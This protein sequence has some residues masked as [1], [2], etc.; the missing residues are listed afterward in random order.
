MVLSYGQGNLPPSRGLTRDEAMRNYALGLNERHS[1]ENETCSR[2]GW[3][4]AIEVLS[5]L[6]DL[7][8]RKKAVT[9]IVE[10]LPLDNLDQLDKLVVLCS[11][12]NLEEQGRKIAE[13][14]F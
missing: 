3:E 1:I 11:D 7:D 2:E 10:K 13:V 4:L 5:R 8:L 14:Y 6:H 12:L 9:E